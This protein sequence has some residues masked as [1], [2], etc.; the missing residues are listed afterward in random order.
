MLYLSQ[1]NED[2]H[3]KNPVAYEYTSGRIQQALP[4]ALE[5]LG[6]NFTAYLCGT[7]AMV[8]DIRQTLLSY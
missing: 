1:E 4:E 5:F 3:K 8:D 7:P 2:F 6:N